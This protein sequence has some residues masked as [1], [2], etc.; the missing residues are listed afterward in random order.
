V[1]ELLTLP[2]TKINATSKRGWTALRFASEHGHEGIVDILLAHPLIKVNK[3]CQ[4]GIMPLYGTVLRHRLGTV[5]L[6]LAHPK[7]KANQECKGGATPL[8]IACNMTNHMEILNTLL[9]HPQINVNILHSKS[10]LIWATE[11]C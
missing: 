8:V 1:K 2:R 3:P 4:E 5:K 11:M 7:V 9:A 10:P 6:L